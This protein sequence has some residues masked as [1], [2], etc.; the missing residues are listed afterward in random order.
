M[1]PVNI[2]EPAPDV[3]FPGREPVGIPPGPG[4]EEPPITPPELSV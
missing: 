3:I 4:P 1:D 2:P